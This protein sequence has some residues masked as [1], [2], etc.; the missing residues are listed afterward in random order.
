MSKRMDLAPDD[1]KRLSNLERGFEGEMQFDLLA[2]NIVEER[3]ILNDLRLEVNNMELQ[4]DS[5]IISQGI[6][7]L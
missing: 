7:Y 1:R 6:S 5:L 3:Y 4:I 2:K